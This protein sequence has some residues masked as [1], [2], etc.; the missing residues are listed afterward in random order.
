MDKNT[1]V[2]II[3]KKATCYSNFSELEQG[4]GLINLTNVKII[5]NTIDLSLK[6]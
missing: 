3:F 5:E 2:N 4:G 1:G 6:L